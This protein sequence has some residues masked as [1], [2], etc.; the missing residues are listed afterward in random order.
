MSWAI[1]PDGPDPRGVRRLPIRYKIMLE[2]AGQKA[3]WAHQ[4]RTRFDQATGVAQF[5]GMM[6]R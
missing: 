1:G 5:V 4:A 2:V 6:L 3:W